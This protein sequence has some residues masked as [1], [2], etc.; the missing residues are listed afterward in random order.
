MEC[1]I[2]CDRVGGCDIG[3]TDR[4]FVVHLA[5]LSLPGHWTAIDF[6]LGVPVF[7]SINSRNDP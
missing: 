3:K 6:S 4:I 7:L 1:W 2:N 5:E